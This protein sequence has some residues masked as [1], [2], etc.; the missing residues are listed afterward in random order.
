MQEEVLS[1]MP[2]ISELYK[3]RSVSVV[4]LE[5]NTGKTET[6]NYI[7]GKL[8]LDNHT[9]AV[10]S[11][12]I[13]GEGLDQV[14][15]TSKPEITLQ[16]GMYFTT[17]EKHYQQRML[18]SEIV[19]VSNHS[20]ALGRLVTALVKV[21]GK[22][23]LSGP[24]DTANLQRLLKEH[25]ALNIQL[26]LVDGALSRMSLASPT[27]TEAMVLATGAAYSAN[28]NQLIKQTKFMCDLISLPRS[29]EAVVPPTLSY[30]KGIWDI[31]SDNEW[32]KLA[33]PSAL[34]FDKYK[35]LLFQKGQIG[36]APV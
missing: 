20:T 7:I 3:Y 24:S 33:I 13:D 10:T 4:G 32:H 30:D 31:D 6:L 18:T 26:T 21:P 9:T 29:N 8:E 19:N 12:G 25:E 15:Q 34:M 27:V 5:K 1:N 11:I 23:M 28:M 36:R 14:T 22:V 2:F 16:E 17:S 35:E